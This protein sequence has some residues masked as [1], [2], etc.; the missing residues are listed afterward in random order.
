MLA[1]AI[2]EMTRVMRADP[3]QQGLD[4]VGL[5]QDSGESVQAPHWRTKCQA[6]LAYFSRRLF[7]YYVICESVIALSTL[8]AGTH[9]LRA[10]ATPQCIWSGLRRSGVRVMS[11]YGMSVFGGTADLARTTVDVRF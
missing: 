7:R 2:R 8:A 5:G 11:D 4:H 6:A 10:I 3:R 9:P 1:R